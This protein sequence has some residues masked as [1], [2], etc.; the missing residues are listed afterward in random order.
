MGYES[1][2]C[3]TILEFA[4]TGVQNTAMEKTN[5]DLKNDDFNDLESSSV[6]GADPGNSVV[7]DPEAERSYGN[8]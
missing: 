3:L 2:C 6:N 4:M 5:F 8:N 1:I 7:I